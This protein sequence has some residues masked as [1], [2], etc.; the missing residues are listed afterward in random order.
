MPSHRLS[1]HLKLE[2]AGEHVE[3]V[4]ECVENWLGT[5]AYSISRE[6]DPKLGDTVRRAQITD[7]PPQ[8][9]S[10]LIGDA[11]H[12]L[13]TALDHVVYALAEGHTPSALTPEVASKLM[14]PIIGNENCKGKPAKG[15][16]IFANVKGTWLAGVPAQAV[17]FIE[18]E[19][20][21]YYDPTGI[22]YKWTALW[23][24]HDLERIDKH[25]R[26]HVTTAWLGLQYLTIP[27]HAGPPRVTYSRVEGPVQHGDKLVTYSGADEGIEAHFTRDVAFNEGPA[28]TWSVGEALDNIGDRVGWITT[29]L[30]R[31][32]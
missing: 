14:F 11:L 9:L 26:L 7:S 30:E 13:R 32:L 27:E 20:P 6:I 17:S 16:D 28:S 5:E 29:T 3:A 23:M 25:R 18:S 2:R 15:S 21:Y 24:L 8:R 12:N 4:K 10:L 19:Q 31:W 1:H 22:D